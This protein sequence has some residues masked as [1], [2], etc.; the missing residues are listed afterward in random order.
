MR[1]GKVGKKPDAI[2]WQEKYATVLQCNGESRNA[3]DIV[4]QFF[5][6]LWR[7]T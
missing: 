6:Y 1:H 2:A 7:I 5:S 3:F 4:F